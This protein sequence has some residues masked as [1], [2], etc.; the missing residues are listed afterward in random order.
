MDNQTDE[1]RYNL[2]RKAREIARSNHKRKSTTQERAQHYIELVRDPEFLKFI[3]DLKTIQVEKTPTST[4]SAQPKESSGKFE[5][6]NVEQYKPFQWTNYIQAG[7]EL[8]DILTIID[9]KQAPNILIEADKGVGKTTLAYE[10]AMR[11]GSHIVGYPCSSGTREGD[12]KGRVANKSGMYQLGYVIV[13]IE[14]ANETGKCILYLDELNALEPELQ[15][16]LNSVLDDRRCI[17]ANGKMFKLNKGS[18]LIVM[19]TMNPSTYAGTVPLNEDLRSR[20]SGQIWDYPKVEHLEKIIDWAGIPEDKVKKPLLQLAQ[21]TFNL[22]VKGEVDY[23]LTTRDLQDFCEH[24]RIFN[25]AGKNPT[26]C[27]EKALSYTVYIKY[28]D[29]GEK[30]LMIK[31]AHD[32]FP[33]QT[34]PSSPPPKRPRRR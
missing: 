29:K 2:T 19:A 28:G 6:I 21:D 15:K 24:Y 10:I 16:M 23:V 22:K 18:K 1:I 7:D 33:I 25:E 12:L 5:T 14:I 9:K 30:E 17:P 26:Q 4:T 13:A 11:I 32:T 27:L 3:K 20:F 8:D 31:S 34:T